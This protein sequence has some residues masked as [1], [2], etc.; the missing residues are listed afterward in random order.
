MNKTILAAAGAG[1]LAAA[2]WVGWTADQLQQ[3]DRDLLARWAEVHA[4]EQAQ[5]S[6]VPVVLA[7]VDQKTAVDPSVR[8]GAR[9]RCGQLGEFDNGDVLMDD[10]QRFDRYKQVR[11]ECT[12]QLFRLMAAVRAD[13]ALWSDAHVRGLYQAMTQGQTAVDAARDRYRHALKSYNAQVQGLPTRVAAVVLGY[14]ERPD[15][16]RMAQ[17]GA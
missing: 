9:A 6:E 4:A 1:A 7:L 15:F 2:A 5:L 16:V 14:R 3:Q 10:E 13:P 8:A 17:Q 11:A 12:G